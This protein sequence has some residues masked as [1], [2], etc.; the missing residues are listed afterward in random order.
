MRAE[1]EELNSRLGSMSGEEK[2]L[3]IRRLLEENSEMKARL[4]IANSAA[5]ELAVQFRQIKDEKSALEKDKK[6]LIRQ[7]RN[8]TDQL[9]KRKKDLFGRK[10]E[11]SSGIIDSIFD[12]D[13]EDPIDESSLEPADPGTDETAQSQR[14]AAAAAFEA[15]KHANGTGKPRG[16]KTRGKRK[17]DLDSFPTRT[18]YDFDADALNQEHGEGNWR[19]AFWRREDTIE[20]VHTVQ[21]HQVR[22]RAVVSVGLEHDLVSRPCTKLMPGS[23]ASESLVAEVMYQK[24]VQCIPSYRMEQDFTRSGIPVSRQTITNWINRFSNELLV[25]AADYMADLLVRRSYSQCDETP[26]QVIMDNRRAGSKSYM[27]V[28]TTSELDQNCPIIVFRFELTRKTDHLR[29][30]YGDAGFTGNIT[31]DCYCSYD[32]LEE[33]YAL[34]HGSRCLMHARR[35][36]YYAAMLV[37]VKGKSME[38]L[39]EL[40]E[41]KALILIDAINEADQLLKYVSPEERLRGRQT[42]VRE[43]ADAF[44]DYLRTLD[45]N[46]PAYTDTFRD[47]IRYALKYEKKLRRFLDDPMIPIDNGFCERSIKPFATA[48]RNWLFSYSVTG[49]EAA[50]TLFTLIETAKANDAHP[51]YYLKYLLETLPKHKVTKNKAFLD[52]CMPWSETYRAYEKQEKEEAMRF[53]ADQVPPKRPR[54]PRKKDKCA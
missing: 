32:I 45:P 8:L 22:Y 50:A 27:W 28:H 12:E 24:A 52:D 25:T 49:A 31:S 3:L 34:I 40:P 51:Y 15:A 5:A 18:V 37:K 44:F 19:I 54:T 1:L 39:G 6:E 13:P 9:Q 2:D 21:Y 16:H 7:N 53:F 36:F 46:D 4:E 29:S 17:K 48:R 35:N 30:F 23:L 26:Y 20:S 38:E 41:F 47:A 33:E 10:S 42:V 14:A 11:Q 43:K